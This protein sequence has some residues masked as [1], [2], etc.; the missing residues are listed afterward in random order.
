MALLCFWYESWGVL[1]LRNDT[2]E[3]MKFMMEIFFA[4][5]HIPEKIAALDMKVFSFFIILGVFLLYEYVRCL[6]FWKPL[7]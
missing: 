6:L 1:Y 5:L 4:G 2:A 7:S 3:G